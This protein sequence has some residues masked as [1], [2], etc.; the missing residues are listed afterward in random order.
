MAHHI[1]KLNWDGKNFLPDP[2]VLPVRKD[3][4]ISFLLAT[5]P[6]NSTFLITLDPAFFSASAVGDSSTRVGIRKA[7]STYG[8][9]L[10]DESGKPLAAKGQAGGSTEPIKSKSAK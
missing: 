6:P 1:V 3:D 10:F 5:A 2:K 8:C 7:G 9:Q 4:T